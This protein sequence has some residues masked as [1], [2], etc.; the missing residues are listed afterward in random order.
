MAWPP[1]N[2]QL[3]SIPPTQEQFFLKY[4]NG[5]N[6]VESNDVFFSLHAVAL[7]LVVLVQ[8]FLYEVRGE[9]GT[10]PAPPFGRQANTHHPYL[11][12]YARHTR[13]CS[14]STCLLGPR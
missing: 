1:L 7:T 9:L 11:P 10:Y 2:P 12:F 6:P 4:P 3:L 8:C 5:V 13:V 14:L